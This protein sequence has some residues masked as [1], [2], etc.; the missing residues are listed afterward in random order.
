MQS[1]VPRDVPNVRKEPS[2]PTKVVGHP[3]HVWLV[4]LDGIRTKPAKDPANSALLE[5]TIQTWEALRLALVEPAQLDDTKIKRV[6]PPASCVLQ[7]DTTPTRVALHPV[8]V[9]PADQETIKTNR[10]SR[11]AKLALLDNTNI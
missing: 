4:P 11:P 8:H 7:D 9:W 3:A 1:E 2:T 5:N 6:N 10:A